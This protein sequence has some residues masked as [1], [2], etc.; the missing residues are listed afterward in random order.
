MTYSPGSPGNSGY[1]PGSYGAPSPSY[2][3]VAEAGPSKLPQYLNIAV[4]L[5]GLGAYVAAF[6]PVFTASTNVGPFSVRPPAPVA[7]C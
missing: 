6:G 1:P 7:S 2:A 3:P 4:V 5:L